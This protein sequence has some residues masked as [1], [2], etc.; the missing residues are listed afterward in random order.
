MHPDYAISLNN[1]A[2]LHK[3]MGQYEKAIALY[4]ES[5]GLRE[6]KGNRNSG[7]IRK[8]SNLVSLH[9]ERGDY[10]EAR[11]LLTEVLPIGIEV[12]GKEHDLYAT[13]LQHHAEWLWKTGEFEKGEIELLQVISIIEKA[14]GRDHK[15]YAVALNK[16]AELYLAAREFDKSETYFLKA[17]AGKEEILGRDHPDY[18]LSLNGVAR[19]YFTIKEYDK[20]GIYFKSA[21]ELNKGLLEKAA[22][23]LSG[24]ELQKY[25][26][27]FESSATMYASFIHQS[28]SAN[29]A[30][31]WYNNTLFYKG[32][33]LD[34][35]LRI[36]REVNKASNEV[37]EIHSEWKGY[38]RRLAAQYAKPI[39]KRKNII[40]LEEQANV[41]EK[42]LLENLPAIKDVRRRIN[43]K[44]VQ[45]QL[46]EGEIA[47]EFT[48]FQFFN[49]FA[50]DSIMYVALVILPGETTPKMIPLFEEGEMNKLLA[51]EG[52]RRADYVN[53]LYSLSDRGVTALKTGS[54]AKTLFEL[55]CA[56]LSEVLEGVEAIYFAPSGLL[57]RLNLGAIPIA[58]EE[59]LAS[60]YKLV[61]LNSTRQLVLPTQVEGENIE[62]MLYGGIQYYYET[63]TTQADS[64]TKT[65]SN[66]WT[67]LTGTAREV[68]KLESI[69]DETGLEP[70]IMTGTAGT[71]ESFKELGKSENPSPRVLHVATH[72]Y[73]FP[74]PKTLNAHEINE[75][76]AV[77]QISDHPMLRSGLIFA[78]GNDFM[79][80]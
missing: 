75:R 16:L 13:L 11:F 54:K 76:E 47:I 36:E 63:D 22:D 69:M 73:F 79:G 48:H 30:E 53:A 58:E 24:I 27:K 9:L 10:D 38:N 8:V 71:E 32:L 46:K 49:P 2:L 23:H 66:F 39:S 19:L 7:Y 35:A 26:L 25:L 5:I 31:D 59:N 41:L 14:L 56:P 50:T 62:V 21:N 72:G 42:E 51:T 4:K 37:K 57:H 18:V 61:Q 68:Q 67:Y 12:L 44:E 70:I 45:D 40:E 78:G 17:I 65:R 52:A 15:K 20:A 43:W 55:I 60:K 80:K 34:N 74:D 28:Q 6:K 29:L 64:L 77:F 3:K 1:L 33:L